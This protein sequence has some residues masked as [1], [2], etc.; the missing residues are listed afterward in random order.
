MVQVS[1]HV[2]NESGINNFQASIVLAQ[3]K[4]IAAEVKFLLADICH[5]LTDHF[6]DVF[7]HYCA[8]FGEVSNEKA[9]SVDFRRSYVDVICGFFDVDVLLFTRSS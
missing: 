1:G 8:L 3:T 6:S 4:H 2:A 5:C 9:Q 7:N